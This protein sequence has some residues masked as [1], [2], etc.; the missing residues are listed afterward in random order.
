M[1]TVTVTACTVIGAAL[2]AIGMASS[3]AMSSA[4][5]FMVFL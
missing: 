4:R 2:A 1:P 5:V 3:A